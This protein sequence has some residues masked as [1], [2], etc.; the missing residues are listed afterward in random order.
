[1]RSRPNLISYSILITRQNLISNRIGSA[2]VNIEIRSVW[3]I[4][5]IY[6]ILIISPELF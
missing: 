2:A 6:Y 4:Y 3:L 5:K 1:M